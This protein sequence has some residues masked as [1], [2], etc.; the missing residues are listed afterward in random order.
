MKSLFK[1]KHHDVL[2]NV[3]YNIILYY[4]ILYKVSIPI[5]H[6]IIQQLHNMQFIDTIK[7]MKYLKA[8]S[9]LP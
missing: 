4:I 2:I 3:I 9:M 8:Y 7:I 1:W 6:F 5:R